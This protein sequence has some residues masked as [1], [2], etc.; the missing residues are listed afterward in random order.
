MRLSRRSAL[1]GLLFAPLLRVLPKV[2]APAAPVVAPGTYR[3]IFTKYSYNRM[4]DARP[5]D[6]FYKGRPLL[7]LLREH[8]ADVPDKLVYR[9]Y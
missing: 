6:Q 8:K 5:G 3:Y 9:I 4:R 7:E 2:P 1:L